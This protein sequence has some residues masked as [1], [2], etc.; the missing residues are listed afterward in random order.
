[1]DGSADLLNRE[2]VSLRRLSTVDYHRMAEAGILEADE[3]IELIE[4]QLVAMSP[5][6]PRH[7]L[8]VDALTELFVIAARGRAKVR[9]QNPVVLNGVNEPNPDLVLARIGW[10][11]F[12]QEHPGPDDILLL[13][14]VADSSLATDR[15]VK[16]GLYARA[17]VGEYWIVDLTRNTVH[18]HRRPRD[19]DYD[20]VIVVSGSD[21]L[22]MAALPDFTVPV[23]SLFI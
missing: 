23:H 18:V 17:G 10:R 19:G 4:G 22:D 15:R 12:P 16:R 6:G 14:E 5:I 3:R 1:M 11:G 8:A 7:A 20:T 21:V 13:V 9:V 2:E